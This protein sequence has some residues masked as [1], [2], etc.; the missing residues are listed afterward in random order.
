MWG[1]TL[2]QSFLYISYLV[3]AYS[4]I[5][6]N[7]IILQQKIGIAVGTLDNIA[8]NPGEDTANSSTIMLSSFSDNKLYRMG[9]KEV[10]SDCFMKAVTVPLQQ[11]NEAISSFYN[12][13]KNPA[14]KKRKRDDNP[15]LTNPSTT[16]GCVVNND[17]INSLQLTHTNKLDK[18]QREEDA[19]KNRLVKIG[20]EA[21][22]NTQVLA[23]FKLTYPCG[24]W[25]NFT[26]ENIKPLAKCCGVSV[27]LNKQPMIV[28]IN[29]KMTSLLNL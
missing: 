10:A 19:I 11:Q 5:V 17:V 28:A 15:V 16:I 29:E 21:F 26:V 9:I 7:I 14:G 2:T 23:E 6:F 24:L 22:V 8:A 27:S 25:R 12:A 3:Y 1:H 13:N 4:I 20:N 18:K